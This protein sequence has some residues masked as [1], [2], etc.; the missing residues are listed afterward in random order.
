MDRKVEEP[1]SP[2]DSL[3]EARPTRPATLC[4]TALRSAVRVRGLWKL[5]SKLFKSR[6]GNATPARFSFHAIPTPFH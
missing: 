2:R 6:V 4:F 3:T 1:K 5:E